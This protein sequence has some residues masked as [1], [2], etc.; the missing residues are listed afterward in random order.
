MEALV[1]FIF[2]GSKVTADSDCRYEIQ[3][4]LLLGRKTM[5]N[6]DSVLKNTDITLPTKVHIVKDSFPNTHAWMCELDHNEG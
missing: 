1:G 4:H 6:I 2:L 3:R 5:T